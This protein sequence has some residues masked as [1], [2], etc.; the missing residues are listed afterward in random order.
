MPIRLIAMTFLKASR[1]CAESNS[2]SRPMVRCAQPM[3]AELTSTR[4]GPSSSACVDRGLDLLGVGDVDA[5]ERAADLLGEGLAL[6][7]LEVG[8][9]DLGARGGELA[10]DGRA[11]AGRRPGDDALSSVDV[12]G[13]RA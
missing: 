10:G 12:H 5:D 4:S 9:D 2:P 6:L 13:W 8:D 3:P 1:S 11:D 7:G